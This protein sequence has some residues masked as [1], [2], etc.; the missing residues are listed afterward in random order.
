MRTQELECDTKA[1]GR[2]N[3]VLG[4]PGL[5]VLNALLF[6]FHNRTTGLTCPSYD[7]LETATGLCREAVARG[8]KRL[9]AAGILDKT[10]RLVRETIYR[11]GVPL[12]VVRQA[13]NLYAMREPPEW[14]W[15]I[16]VTPFC[17]APE[18]RPPSL[19]CARQATRLGRVYGTGR[20]QPSSTPAARQTPMT[21]TGCAA[22][23]AHP[24]AAS[25]LLEVKK[26]AW[27]GRPANNISAFQP[28]TA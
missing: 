2:V 3:G 20:N 7:A 12:K 4:W 1:K 21:E 25:F 15:L 11:G 26:G 8:V 17:Q 23:D 19:R 14:A 5:R 10:R 27:Q 13:S 28:A 16:P 6:K 22:S 18:L 9:V 24:P